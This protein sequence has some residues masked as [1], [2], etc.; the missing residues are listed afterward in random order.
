MLMNFREFLQEKQMKLTQ[1]LYYK[2]T[3]HTNE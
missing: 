2:M 1:V 3:L